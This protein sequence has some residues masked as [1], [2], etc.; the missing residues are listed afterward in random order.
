MLGV[1]TRIIDD[2]IYTAERARDILPERL[3]CA[4]IAQICSEE[5]VARASHC[6][7]RLLRPGAIGVEVQRNSRAARGQR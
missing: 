6:A 7:P 1:N 4:G 3:D 5:H 2:H